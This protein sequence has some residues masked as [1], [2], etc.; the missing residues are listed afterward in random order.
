MRSDMRGPKRVACPRC[1]AEAG[2]Y[3]R[4]LRGARKGRI[5]ANYYHHARWDAWHMERQP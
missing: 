2:A 3:C 5:L 4:T 1:K